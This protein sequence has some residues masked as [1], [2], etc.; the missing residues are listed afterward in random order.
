MLEK[1][2]TSRGNTLVIQGLEAVIYIGELYCTKLS[3]K[4][5]IHETSLIKVYLQL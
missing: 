1:M 4:W 3:F 2:Y 5:Y